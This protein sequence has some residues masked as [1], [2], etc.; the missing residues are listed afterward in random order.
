MRTLID[1]RVRRLVGKAICEYDLLRDGDR[2]LVGISGGKDSL[3]ML[4]V[5]AER[6]KM[7][8]INYELFPLLVDLGFGPIPEKELKAF[9]ESLGLELLIKKTQIGPKSLNSDE[10]PCFLCSRLRRKVLFESASELGCNKIALGHNKDDLL[11]TFF[12]NVLYSGEIS[13]MVP[14]Q[15]LFQGKLTIIRPL[16]L[17]DEEKIEA[18]SQLHRLPVLSDPCPV[19]GHTRRAQIK[20]WLNLIF[21][22]DPHTKGNAFHALSN[23]NLEYLLPKTNGR[24]GCS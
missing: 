9:V 21:K 23:V 6:G 13:T 22:K 15:E 8:P 10:T 19:R 2:V 3:T 18:F 17:V 16:C 4:K 5:L 24:K 20:E 7:V 14:K 12:L 1:K 11:V